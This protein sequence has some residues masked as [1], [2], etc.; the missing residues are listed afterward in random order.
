MKVG[1]GF[2]KIPILFR[3][4]LFK[5]VFLPHRWP[6]ILETFGKCCVSNEKVWNHSKNVFYLLLEHF[7]RKSIDVLW[8]APWSGADPERSGNHGALR[9]A[10]ERGAERC[11][12]SDPERSGAERAKRKCRA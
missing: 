11:P 1:G 2:T 12:R 4:S 8:S 10:P 6:V 3:K 7:S 5:F 9:S